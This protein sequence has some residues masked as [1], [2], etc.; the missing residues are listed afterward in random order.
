MAE[1]QSLYKNLAGS[2]SQDITDT[3]STVLESI[4]LLKKIGE[5]TF[6]DADKDLEQIAN[7]ETKYIRAAAKAVSNDILLQQLYGKD[8]S[9]VLKVSKIMKARAEESEG[10]RVL[11]SY[12][13]NSDIADKRSS[14]EKS[15]DTMR[16][17][18]T[19]KNYVPAPKPE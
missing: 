19:G 10:M 15:L 11:D 13:E 7:A 4:L 14:A 6:K 9:A 8:L 18:V 5:T 12:L 17:K 1:L 2:T 3:S 16:S